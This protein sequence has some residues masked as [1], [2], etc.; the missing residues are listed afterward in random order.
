MATRELERIRQS[1]RPISET[2]AVMGDKAMAAAEKSGSGS[3]ER[4]NKPERQCRRCR[5]KA[6]KPR[7]APAT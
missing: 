6:P 3:I 5:R 4:W 1:D 7:G 2:A